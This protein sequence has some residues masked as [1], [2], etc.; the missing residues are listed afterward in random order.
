MCQAIAKMIGNARREDL[1]FVLEPAKC[2]RVHNAVAITLKFVAIGMR[3][4][5]KSSPA[6]VFY[7]KSKMGE[8]TRHAYLFRPAMSAS[9][10][11]ATRLM[12]ERSIRSGSSIFVAA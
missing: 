2:A 6:G 8:R 1:R 12:A 5:G 10:A 9:A 3:K 11:T 7:R 4:L